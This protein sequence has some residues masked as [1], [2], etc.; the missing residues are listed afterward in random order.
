MQFCLFLFVLLQNEKEEVDKKIQVKQEEF[1]AVR[2]KVGDLG[3]KEGGKTMHPLVERAIQLNSTLIETQK[4]RLLLEASYQS[5]TE[6]IKAGQNI[7][8]SLIAIEET[9]GKEINSLMASLDLICLK[10]N[11]ID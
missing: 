8:Q 1:L 10:I 4:K 3:I 7:R 9:L 2:K 5:L 11:T 6:A